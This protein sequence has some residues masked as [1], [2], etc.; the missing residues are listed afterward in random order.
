M[1]TLTYIYTVCVYVY[2]VNIRFPNKQ[3]CSVD[4]VE[5]YSMWNT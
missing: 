1:E 4:N 2:I 3:N 5:I